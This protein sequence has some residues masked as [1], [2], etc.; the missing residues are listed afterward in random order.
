MKPTKPH[1]GEFTSALVPRPSKTTGRSV[2]NIATDG[3][4]S[5]AEKISN[6]MPIAHVKRYLNKVRLRCDR[7]C[8]DASPL[9]SS[10]QCIAKLIRTSSDGLIIPRISL[11]GRWDACSGLMKTQAMSDSVMKQN[12]SCAGLA[13]RLHRRLGQPQSAC[14]HRDSRTDSSRLFSRRAHSLPCR[15]RPR[16]QVLRAPGVGCGTHQYPSYIG[17]H[18]ARFRDLQYVIFA[19]TTLNAAVRGLPC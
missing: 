16:K 12:S 8:R 5:A 1:T 17:S 14:R 15:R 7:L 3:H 2:R 18:S 6:P 9:R 19:G 11:I 13:D 10:A 4:S